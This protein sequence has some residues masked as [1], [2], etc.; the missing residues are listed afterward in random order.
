MTYGLGGQKTQENGERLEECLKELAEEKAQLA[1]LERQV[2]VSQLVGTQQ[3]LNNLDLQM[4]INLMHLG[5]LQ[6]VS[7]HNYFKI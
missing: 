1:E 6:M 4:K 2:A 5:N 3:Q 7:H